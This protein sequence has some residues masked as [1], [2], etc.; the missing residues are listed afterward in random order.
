MRDIDSLIALVSD[1]ME[2]VEQTLMSSIE[3]R[4]DVLNDICRHILSSG[5]KR[6]RPL[7]LLLAAKF[8]GYGGSDH[9]PLACV[10]EYIHTATLLHDDVIDHAEIRRGSSSAHML[11]GNQATILSGDYFFS[12]AFSMAVGVGN[13]R[14]LNKLMARVRGPARSPLFEASIVKKVFAYVVG[15]GRG[16]SGY[17]E[18]NG[19]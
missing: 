12:R 11:W 15:L 5:G 16:D 2:R 3:T 4:V 6:I 13:V 7:I 18:Q 9:I 1:D 19:P 14:I 8:C 10:L 17:G